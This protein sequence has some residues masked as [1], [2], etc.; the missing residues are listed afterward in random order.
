MKWFWHKRAE[1]QGSKPGTPERPSERA[2]AQQAKAELS[3]TQNLVVWALTVEKLKAEGN[4]QEANVLHEILL[5][6]LRRD[7]IDSLLHLTLEG[8]SLKAQNRNAEAEVVYRLAME[9]TSEL[10]ADDPL[11]ATAV[12]N[13]G[14]LYHEQGRLAEAEPLYRQSLELLRS[15]P[16]GKDNSQYAHTTQRLGELYEAQGRLG[17]A[18][19]CYEEVRAIRRRT[20]EV[21]GR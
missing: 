5:S 1:T 13:L 9:I 18:R 17:D 19:K 11:Y 20:P 4:H 3:P 6:E 7:S 15:T 16:L 14:V 21:S 10:G 12:G 8:R 2:P